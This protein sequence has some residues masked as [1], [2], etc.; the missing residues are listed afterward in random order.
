MPEGEGSSG[1]R[2]RKA[3]LRSR[4]FSAV[5]IFKGAV[6][7]S[8]DAC[9]DA[10][11]GGAHFP[12]PLGHIQPSSRA[13]SGCSDSDTDSSAQGYHDRAYKVQLQQQS[14]EKREKGWQSLKKTS[15]T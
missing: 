11:F 2:N 5:E 10:L 6:Q 12:Q 9:K 14:S 4:T 8:G 7:E 13:H 15:S 1:V 3:P